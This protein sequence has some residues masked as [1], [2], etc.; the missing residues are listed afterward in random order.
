VGVDRVGVGGN[1]G[2]GATGWRV[3]SGCRGGRRW[4]RTRRSVTSGCRGG[5]RWVR[6]RRSVIFS[7]ISSHAKMNTSVPRFRPR[8]LSRARSRRRA[9]IRHR[10]V[11]I[12]GEPSHRFWSPGVPSSVLERSPRLCAPERVRSLRGVSGVLA[13]DIQASPAGSHTSFDLLPPTGHQHPHF[14][15]IFLCEY[16]R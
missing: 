15:H 11:A 3:T 14:R 4:V 16:I 10:N 6:T 7:V 8:L 12:E 1:G 2:S 13:R 9:R 5:R